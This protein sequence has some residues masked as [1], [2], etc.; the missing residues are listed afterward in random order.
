MKKILLFALLLSTQESFSQHVNITNITSKI[1]TVSMVRQGEIIP[2]HFNLI[3]SKSL[4]INPTVI[5]DIY[6][7][8]I[9][10]PETKNLIS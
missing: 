8:S 6:I 2:I 10:E 5:Q 7:Q 1:L 9:R 4:S 3:P